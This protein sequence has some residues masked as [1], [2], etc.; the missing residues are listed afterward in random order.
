ML[1]VIGLTVTR[2]VHH[3][4]KVRA[5]STGVV[6]GLEVASV[7]QSTDRILRELITIVA[8]VLGQAEVELVVLLA[9]QQSLWMRRLCR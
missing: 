2:Q 1:N 3:N 4:I 8:D 9:K 7:S 6:H 5:G